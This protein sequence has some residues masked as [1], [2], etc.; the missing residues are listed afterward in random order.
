MSKY[1]EK[2]H[3]SNF[4]TKKSFS[5]SENNFDDDPPLWLDEA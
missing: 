4:E 3:F 2:K 5:V 1:G